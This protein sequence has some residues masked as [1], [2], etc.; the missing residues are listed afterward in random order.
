MGT[1]AAWPMCKSFFEAS[2]VGKTI[3]W[4]VNHVYYR[5]ERF[6]GSGQRPNTTG[7]TWQAALCENQRFPGKAFQGLRPDLIHSWS[8]GRHSI[9]APKARLP[10][11]GT[12]GKGQGGCGPCLLPLP[13][14]PPH[15]RPR[16]PSLGGYSSRKG[17]APAPPGLSLSPLP[18]ESR[19][20]CV[21]CPVCPVLWSGLVCPHHHSAV[22]LGKEG[23]SRPFSF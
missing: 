2:N 11:P 19:L 13:G 22:G 10:F 18:L 6:P 12:W 3:I 14:C 9:P 23:T 4:S 5:R 21:L 16:P 15:P 8:R 1:G 17:A 20:C 7:G